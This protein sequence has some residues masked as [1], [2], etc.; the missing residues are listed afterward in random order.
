MTVA[1]IV[2]LAKLRLDPVAGEES[3]QQ[4]KLLVAAVIGAEA[5]ALMVHTWMEVTEEQIVIL[6]ELLERRTGGEPLQYILGEWEFM[7]LPFYVDERALI[8]RQDTE[9]LCE[10]ALERIKNRGC[11]S[12][13]DLCTGSGCL[14]VA[15]QRLSGVR[16]AASDV[17][18]DALALAGE[19]AALNEAQI[20]LITSDLFEQIPGTFDLIVC[21]P[22]YLTRSDMDHLQKEVTF[23][24][25]LALFGGEDGLDF[26][27][28]IAGEYRAHLNPG[29]T[30]LIEIGSTQAESVSALFG[31]NTI[32]LNDLGGN[33]RVLIA[34][35]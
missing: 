25:R 21:N 35:Y 28:R 12:V 8:P 22:P 3:L 11:Q 31:G 15:I 20:E 29:G 16:V 2:R 17:S 19:N 27:R 10:T 7:G 5:D 14:A 13:L 34:E 30:L 4:A 32:L 23:E 18:P 1:E 24:P 6:G 9:L 33:P 26:Y